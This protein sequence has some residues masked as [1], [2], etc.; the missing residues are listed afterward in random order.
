MGEP[1]GKF[2]SSRLR[3]VDPAHSAYSW[4]GS[5]GP[6]WGTR[7]PSNTGIKV[8]SFKG[9]SMFAHVLAKPTHSLPET[10]R[11]RAPLLMRAAPPCAKPLLPPGRAVTWKTFYQCQM[12]M[13][14]SRNSTW[15]RIL[16]NKKILDPS[17]HPVCLV[18]FRDE[19]S[20]LCKTVPLELRFPVFAVPCLSGLYFPSVSEL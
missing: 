12:I 10:G 11:H 7:G 17:G 8:F 3:S 1:H 13:S 19:M 15:K 16:T 9:S 4:S 14:S 18:W 20:Q 6:C 5:R 2:P